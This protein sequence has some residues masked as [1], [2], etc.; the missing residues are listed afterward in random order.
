M[1]LATFSVG[2]LLRIGNLHF[3]ATE[4]HVGIERTAEKQR[5][6]EQFDAPGAKSRKREH[7]TVVAF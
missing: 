1:H 7:N 4:H 3:P 2:H 6:G 5:I